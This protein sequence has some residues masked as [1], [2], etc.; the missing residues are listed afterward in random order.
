MESMNFLHYIPEC[1][2][3]VLDYSGR[4]SYEE[5][6][7]R[8]DMLENYFIQYAE[9]A[10]C[11]KLL[12]DIRKT[13]WDTKETHDALSKRARHTFRP[14]NER[15]RMYLAVVNAEYTAH[16]SD[17]EQWFTEKESAIEWLRHLPQRADVPMK[18]AG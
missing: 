9:E 8:M 7:A 13:I 3:H 11:I 16:I 17:I 6:L 1:D 5:G 12:F 2:I 14:D 18:T 10:S 15:Y 4:I